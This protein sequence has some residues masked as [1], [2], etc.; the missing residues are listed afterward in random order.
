MGESP[1]PQLRR[2][3]LLVWILVALFYFYLSY[4]YIRASVR[5]KSLTEYLDH[6]VQLAGSERRPPKEVRA[7]I[8]VKAEELGIPLSSEQIDIAGAGQTLAVSVDY[9]TDIEIP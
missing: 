4:D 6:V 9:Q 8:L 7:L 2:L 1:K 3:V 5:D